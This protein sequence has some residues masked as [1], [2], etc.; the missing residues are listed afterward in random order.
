MKARAL[1]VVKRYSLWFGMAAV[2]ASS[3][4]TILPI[5]IERLLLPVRAEAPAAREC[6]ARRTAEP[7]RISGSQGQ[8]ESRGLMRWLFDA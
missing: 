4:F 2:S 1:R 3:S 6:K 5:G 7:Q 8:K